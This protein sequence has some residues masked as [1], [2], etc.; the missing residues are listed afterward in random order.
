MKKFIMGAFMA[1]VLAVIPTV[2]AQAEPNTCAGW[3]AQCRAECTPALQANPGVPKGCTCESR[4]QTCKATKIW[5]SWRPG[6]PGHPVK[7]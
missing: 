6:A 2:G 1:G 3:L 5:Q 7:N 4:Y